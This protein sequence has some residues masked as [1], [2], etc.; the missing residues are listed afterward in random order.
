M[1]DAVTDRDP[2]LLAGG[3]GDAAHLLEQP[4]FQRVGRATAV[5]ES[6]QPVGVVSMTDIERTIR[7]NRLDS[8]AGP[9]Q[10]LAPHV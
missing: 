8:P 6:G 7:A 9:P 1:V 3:S 2:A 10:R 5:D 4:A